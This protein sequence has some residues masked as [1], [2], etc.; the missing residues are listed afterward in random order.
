MGEDQS[1]SQVVARFSNPLAWSC[2]TFQYSNPVLNVAP[3]TFT[4]IDNLAHPVSKPPS[5]L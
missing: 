2:T 4:E 1:K 5:S 3:T